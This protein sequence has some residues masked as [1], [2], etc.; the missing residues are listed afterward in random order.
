VAENPNAPIDVLE[1]LS[2]DPN[3]DV[4]VAVATNASRPKLLV[5]NLAADGDIVVRHGLAQDINTPIDVLEQ[6]S[7]DENA[8]VSGEARKTLH[9]LAT[10]A[11]Q[12]ALG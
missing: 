3:H 10:W 5:Q 4:R 6:L 11:E 2:N 1:K 12:P 8:W 7:H 9:I